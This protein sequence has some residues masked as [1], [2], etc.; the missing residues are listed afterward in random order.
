MK[1]LLIVDDDV[2]LT[3]VYAQLAAELGFEVRVVN[4]PHQALTPFLASG[5]IWRCWT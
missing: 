2:G 1:K 4:D 5:L 3:K